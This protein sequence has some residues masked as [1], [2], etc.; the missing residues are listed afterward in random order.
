M[1]RKYVFG[2]SCALILLFLVLLYAIDRYGRN[3]RKSGTG[4]SLAD[5]SLPK[6]AVGYPEDAYI[7]WKMRGYRG[8]VVVALSKRLNFIEPEKIMTQRDRFPLDPRSQ[9]N[10]LERRLNS[11]NFLFVA[12]KRGIVRKIIHIVPDSDF[13]WRRDAASDIGGVAAAENAIS[14]PYRGS[15]RLITT[16]GHLPATDE[17]V[18]LYINA[19]FFHDHTPDEVLAGLRN[20]RVRTDYVVF[21]DSLEDPEVT[22]EERLRLRDFSAALRT[23]GG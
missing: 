22:E 13:R 19:S 9:G 4:F 14:T 12:M 23:S 11:E 1:K 5:A 16:L 15:P 6:I 21:C 8:R 10:E 3:A 18:L 20:A 2:I 7:A 17:P